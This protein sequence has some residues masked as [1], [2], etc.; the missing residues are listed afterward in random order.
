VNLI[1]ALC[2]GP[3]FRGQVNSHDRAGGISYSSF[4]ALNRTVDSI[5]K[6]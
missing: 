3:E 5:A 2:H 4:D 1:E 6:L